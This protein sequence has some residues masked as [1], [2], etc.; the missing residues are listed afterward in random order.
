MSARLCCCYSKSVRQRSSREAQRRYPFLS[1]SVFFSRLH[2]IV[3]RYII[4]WLQ[5]LGSPEP[6][7]PHPLGGCHFQA[8]SPHRLYALAVA[9]AAATISYSATTDWMI[10]SRSVPSGRGTGMAQLAFIAL[11]LLSLSIHVCASGSLWIS[12]IP[13]GEGGKESGF[14]EREGERQ[15]KRSRSHCI[16]NARES[17]RGSFGLFRA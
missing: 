2:F 17:N 5:H 13:G 16:A 1:L 10:A 4:N 15:R 11:L 3:K 8:A 9:A 14:R 7:S 12:L 6:E